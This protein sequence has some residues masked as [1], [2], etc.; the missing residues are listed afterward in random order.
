[1][2]TIVLSSPT[3]SRRSVT[4]PGRRIAGRSPSAGKSPDRFCMSSPPKSPIPR[5]FYWADPMSTEWSQA[6][7]TTVAGLPSVPIFDV[8]SEVTIDDGT[9]SLWVIG[10]RRRRDPHR[11]SSSQGTLRTRSG[12]R[13]GHRTAGDSRS[14]RRGG[15]GGN[16]DVYVID[17]DGTEQGAGTSPT[18]R[19]RSIG[20]AGP[21]RARESA[22]PKV[23]TLGRPTRG[24]IVVADPD[25][26][27]C[28]RALWYH[29]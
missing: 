1:M 5:P 4:S 2:V 9:G 12:T 26:S 24:A 18:V 10:S 3:N 28:H 21:P 17:A 15:A 8:A 25:G 6:G 19:K 27:H 29:P 14:S 23:S 20:R 11:V 16:F 22:F 7:R 13:P